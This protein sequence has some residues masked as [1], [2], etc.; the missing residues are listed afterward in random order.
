ME[1]WLI[2]AIVGALL[3]ILE[4]FSAGFFMLPAGI[5]FMLTAAIA[6]FL[7][8]WPPILLTLA[9]LLAATYVLFYFAVWPR[10]RGKSRETTGAIGMVGKIAVVTEAITSETGMGY[11]QLYGDSWRAISE[12]PFSTGAKVRILATEGNKVIV[13]PA[14]P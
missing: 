4:V 6:S 13:G 12:T 2:L 7:T 5:A 14:E 11:V 10:V 9:S 1:P 3:A 8:S